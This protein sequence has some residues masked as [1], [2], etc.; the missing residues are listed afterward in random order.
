MPNGFSNVP[1]ITQQA[2]DNLISGNIGGILSTR[3]QAKY[4]S[5][6][7]TV[8]RING[9][10]A[11][12]AFGISWRISTIG[13]ELDTI[14]NIMPEEIVPTKIKVDGHISA[15]HIPGLGAGAQLWQPD[16]MS[17]LFHQ[18]ITIEVRDSATNELL[19]FAPKA[20]ITNRQED[21]RVDQLANVSLSF[22]A[23][24]YRDERNPSYPANID[25][26]SRP[27]SMD[28]SLGEYTT[29]SYD[30]IDLSSSIKPSK[31]VI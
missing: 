21:I 9:K 30:N 11:A 10:P 15:L 1:P 17:F 29:A 28:T 22:I 26:L 5:G 14:D 2:V 12:F 3:P 24:G 8:L 4:A 6:A 16:V 19:F 13:R 25:T 23:I 7:R 18:Y 20:M 27:S 31:K